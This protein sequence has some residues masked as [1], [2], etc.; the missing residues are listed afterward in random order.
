MVTL[1]IV[2]FK[3]R[4]FSLEKQLASLVSKLTSMNVF[5]EVWTALALVE[6]RNI[7]R[8]LWITLS[9]ETTGISSLEAPIKGVLKRRT[10]EQ[11]QWKG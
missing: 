9:R 7:S 4:F 8:Q 11:Y 3:L 1:Q 6:G 5:A 2:L 10:E